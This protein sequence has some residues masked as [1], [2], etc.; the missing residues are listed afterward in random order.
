MI[1][2]IE[3]LWDNINHSCICLIEVSDEKE[4]ERNNECTEKAFEKI[5]PQVP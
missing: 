4:K 2:I 5:V 1:L 3:R